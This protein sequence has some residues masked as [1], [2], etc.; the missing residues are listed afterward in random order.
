LE[1]ERAHHETQCELDSEAGRLTDKV[2]VYELQDTKDFDS[3]AQLYKR[4]FN[5]LYFKNQELS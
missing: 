1:A 3:L 2:V 4:I 5:F